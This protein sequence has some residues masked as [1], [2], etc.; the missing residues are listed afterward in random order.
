MP[1]FEKCDVHQ[2]TDNRLRAVF[3]GKNMDSHSITLKEACQF[4]KI[5]RP[6]AV[7]WIR[8]GRLQATRK[9]SSGKRSPYL[10][11]RQACIAALHSPLHTVKVSA[12]DGITEERKCH[13]SAEVKYG[14]PR[15]R[16]RAGSELRSLLAQRTSGKLRSCTTSEKQNSGE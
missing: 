5:S 9:N 12:G 6:T 11:T 2:S 7:N 14:T 4:L 10:T 15:T 3:N 16:S 8:T 1:A 13:S